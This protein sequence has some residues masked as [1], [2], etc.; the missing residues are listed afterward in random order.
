ML[1]VFLDQTL[2]NFFPA[3]NYPNKWERH[4]VDA[5]YLPNPDLPMSHR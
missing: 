1:V 2:P 3:S 4:S 5:F